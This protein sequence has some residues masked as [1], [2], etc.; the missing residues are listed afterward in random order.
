MRGDDR[1]RIPLPGKRLRLF[2]KDSDI[3]RPMDGG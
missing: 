3:E 2:V 1:H